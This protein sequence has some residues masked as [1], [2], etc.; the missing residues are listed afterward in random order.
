MDRADAFLENL[1]VHSK[2]TGFRWA[3]SI[4][5]MAFKENVHLVTI[6]LGQS[7]HIYPCCHIYIGKEFI[8]RSGLSWQIFSEHLNEI[9]FDL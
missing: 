9:M 6:D 1:N 2:Q 4:C 5:K 8:L 3:A 7:A